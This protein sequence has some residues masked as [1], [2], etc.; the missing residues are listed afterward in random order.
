MV[1]YWFCSSTPFCVFVSLLVLKEKREGGIR[2]VYVL[3]L[4]FIYLFI[5]L[6]NNKQEDVSY[7]IAFSLH[8]EARRRRTHRTGI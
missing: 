1:C 5:Q 8:V 2:V 7:Q 3:L 4:S 6:Y